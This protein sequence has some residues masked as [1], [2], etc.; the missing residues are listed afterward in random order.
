MQAMPGLWREARLLAVSGVARPRRGY[1]RRRRAEVVRVSACAAV[2]VQR[3]GIVCDSRQRE[4]TGLDESADWRCHATHPRNAMD[5]PLGPAQQQQQRWR[6]RRLGFGV[7]GCKSRDRAAGAASGPRAGASRRQAPATGH[8]PRRTIGPRPDA[9]AVLGSTG[10]ASKRRSRTFSKSWRLFDQFSLPKL[11]AR[12]R[13]R[14]PHP[15]HLCRSTRLLPPRHVP[16]LLE[17][18]IRPS[19]VPQAW[20]TT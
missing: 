8:Q 3:P 12:T 9:P 19:S 13:T 14:P 1:I 20:V 5:V 2:A 17:R 4:P 7:G 10:A 6:R 15:V 11:A 18:P 16:S